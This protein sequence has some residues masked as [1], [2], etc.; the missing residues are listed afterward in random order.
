MGLGILVLDPLCSVIA[1]RN[2][3]SAFHIASLTASRRALA[4]PAGKC[5]IRDIPLPLASTIERSA[6]FSDLFRC[7]SARLKSKLCCLT[8]ACSQ[9]I[10]TDLRIG[11]ITEKKPTPFSPPS[12]FYSHRKTLARRH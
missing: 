2:F 9:A 5:V 7:F 12:L 1:D 3:S 11:A 6:P 10:P 8:Y 4:L